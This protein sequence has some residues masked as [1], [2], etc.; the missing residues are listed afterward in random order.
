MD[1]KER[2][3]REQYMNKEVDHQAYYL[4]VAA[5][6]G[7]THRL[8][9]QKM[10]QEVL[11]STDPHLNDVPLHKW[12]RVAAVIQAVEVYNNERR[13]TSLAGTVCALKAVAREYQQENRDAH[14]Q[15]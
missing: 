6:S 7:I 10:L 5:H 14:D 9:P 3:T 15:A 4:D 11:A 2:Y 1:K 13:V 8:L 12:D